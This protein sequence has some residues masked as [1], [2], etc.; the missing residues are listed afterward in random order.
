MTAAALVVVALV[1]VGLY[2]FARHVAAHEHQPSTH[3]NARCA[4][5]GMDRAAHRR[6]VP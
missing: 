4:V 1:L 2:H 6:R 3:P 5:C